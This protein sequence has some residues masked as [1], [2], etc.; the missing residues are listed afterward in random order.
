VIKLTLNA[1]EVWSSASCYRLINFG[2]KRSECQ[3]Q[4]VHA[5]LILKVDNTSFLLVKRTS[6]SYDVTRRFDNKILPLLQH[7]E[8]CGLLLLD[9]VNH[10]LIHI[11]ALQ[12]PHIVSISP[13][14]HR[15]EVD[16]YSS[17]N[18]YNASLPTEGCAHVVACCTIHCKM[19]N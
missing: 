19:K 12:N 14:S 2:T 7:R 3:H 5:N 9:F 15:A 6:S 1:K 4:I 8:N 18:N 17:P 16:A 13:Q 11:F 10:F